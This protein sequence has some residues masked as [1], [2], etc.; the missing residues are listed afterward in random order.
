V[1][2]GRF[3]PEQA[4][5]GQRGGVLRRVLALVGDGVG[6]EHWTLPDHDLPVA[7]L[8]ALG[9]ARPIR[10]R[11]PRC[12]EH[13]CHYLNACARQ[14]VFEEGREG[15]AGRK[16][17]LTA[18]GLALA[19]DP[20][21]A[22]PAPDTLPLAEAILALL[23]AGERTVFELVWALVEPALAGLAAGEEP[24]PPP[25]RAY[26]RATLSLLADHGYVEV[27]AADGR[28]RLVGSAPA[29]TAEA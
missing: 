15:R 21:R 13:G 26:L 29:A 6:C 7:L 11:V 3:A 28:L 22:L 10:Q 17:R 24:P 9:L 12:T 20:A 16:F 18:E 2:G 23:A 8:E 19:G 14:V 4:G 5:P 1:S 25:S 27:D